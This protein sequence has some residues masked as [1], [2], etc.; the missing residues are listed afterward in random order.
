VTK[1][2]HERYF[3]EIAIYRTRRERFNKKYDSDLQ[4][5]LEQSQ[6]LS[7]FIRDIDNTRIHDKQSFWENYGGPW[8]YNQIVGWIRLYILGSQLRGDLWMMTGKRLYRKSRNQIQLVGKVFETD[9]TPDESSTQIR[10][11]L[12]QE[13]EYLQK[14]LCKK[15]R[16]LDLECFQ[17]LAPNIDWRKKTLRR[18]LSSGTIEG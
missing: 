9:I 11:K 13:L 8:Q 2:L 16:F 5:Y 3:F 17:C 15:K 6:K 1:L 10:T 12:E 4:S 7:G 18:G 14:K